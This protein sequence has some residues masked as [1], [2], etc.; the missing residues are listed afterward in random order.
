MVGKKLTLILAASLSVIAPI[1]ADYYCRHHDCDRPGIVAG[2]VEATGDVAEATVDTAG[3]I[4]DD[5][6]GSGT[7][8]NPGNW[9][10]RG[11]QKREANRNARADRRE[12]RRNR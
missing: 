2:T 9:G 3:N 1:S 11:R 6:L 5:T 4:I 10:E 7:I 8:F 12:A